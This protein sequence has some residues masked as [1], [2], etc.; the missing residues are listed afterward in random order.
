LAG[1][2][3]GDAAVKARWLGWLWLGLLTVAAA[4]GVNAPNTGADLGRAVSVVDDRGLTLTL[5]QP[6]QRIVS[7]LPSLTETLCELQAC[8]RLVGTDRFSNWPA[9]VRALP[10]LGGLEDTQIERI[11]ALKPDLVV[12]AV[13]SRA[14][15][16]LAALGLPVLALEPR[17]AVD[18]RRSIERLA[19]ALGTPAAG[20]ALV[21]QLE[22]RINAA[23]ARVPQAWRGQ[24]VYFEVAANPYAAGASSFVGELLTRLGLANIV[25]AGLG[26][27][28]QL[29]P[30][31]VLRAQPGL[32]M[33]SQ[34]A[35]ADMHKRPGWSALLALQQSHVCAF[36]P[37]KHDTL[38]R[39]GPRL[40]AAAE[41]I[42]DCLVALPNPEAKR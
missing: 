18:T 7:L 16:R 38:V 29:N 21:A 32:V 17:N 14:V 35:L 23:A 19:Q 31:F 34:A 36:A 15:D 11:V 10:K 22:A 40:G 30:E 28:P 13:S 1:A 6:P 27:F 4:Q 33:A 24:R 5:A 20:P 9:S 26:P 25:P 3:L 2:A 12:L 42:A 8:A 37:E 39:P 41:A